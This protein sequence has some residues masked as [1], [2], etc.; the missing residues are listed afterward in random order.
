MSLLYHNR[1]ALH[2]GGRRQRWLNEPFLL[3][4]SL[5]GRRKSLSLLSQIASSA[6]GEPYAV[7]S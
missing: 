3:A 5:G 4:V 2:R 6:A 7:F 1:G